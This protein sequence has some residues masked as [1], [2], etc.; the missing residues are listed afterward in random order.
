M[1]IQCW[2]SI[3]KRHKTTAI[4]LTSMYVILIWEWKESNHLIKWYTNQVDVVPLC[5]VTSPF[6]L[7]FE[8]SHVPCLFGAI[9][10]Q[11]PSIQNFPLNFLVLVCNCCL[12]F[13]IIRNSHRFKT[14]L[15]PSSF[16]SLLHKEYM[17]GSK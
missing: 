9:C 5:I 2:Y 3:H 7:I 14:P 6:L 13:D 10:Q 15:G 11:M 12:Y 17:T 8:L 1:N 16:A 4:Q